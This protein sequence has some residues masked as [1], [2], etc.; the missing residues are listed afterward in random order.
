ME[1]TLTMEGDK[2]RQVI[3]YS[4]NQRIVETSGEV[5]NIY[6]NTHNVLNVSVR[7]F[8]R[9]YKKVRINCVDA[10]TKELIKSWLMLVESE[11]PKVTQSHD[12]KLILDRGINREIDFEN[13]LNKEAIFEFASTRP[14]LCRPIQSHVRVGPRMIKRIEFFF[15]PKRVK[16]KDDCL[17]FINDEEYNFYECFRFKLSYIA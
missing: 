13:K 7:T 6:P 15:P 10:N 3:L 9:D 2:K 11:E 4:G 5:Q 8:E 1:Q 17:I 16:G 14:D 12:V